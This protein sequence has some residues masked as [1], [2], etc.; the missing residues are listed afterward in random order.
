V[1][2]NES[3]EQFDVASEHDYQDVQSDFGFNTPKFIIVEKVMP[4]VQMF[5]IAPT[6][7]GQPWNKPANTE[8]P[9]KY[10]KHYN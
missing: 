5:H 8:T 3:A 9:E 4:P 7:F 6:E 10:Q 2:V 1:Y